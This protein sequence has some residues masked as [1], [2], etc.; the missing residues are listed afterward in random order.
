MKTKRTQLGRI[1]SRGAHD[2][3]SIYEAIDAG[4]LCHV[5][6]VDG[7]HPFVIPTA[8]GRQGDFLLLHGSVKSRLM[9][10]LAAGG[11]CCVTITHLDALVL[12]RSTFHHS[13]NYRSV[14]V[15]GKGELVA[16]EADKMEALKVITNNILPGRW[17]ETRLPNPG[18]MKATTVVR[19]PLKEASLKTRTGPPKDDQPDYELDIW[20]GL[21]PLQSGYLPPE[22]DPDLKDGVELPGSLGG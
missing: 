7:G 22:A 17:S 20:A 21:L 13:M 1:P 5:G 15:L 6:F 3:A 2:K 11:D 18:E 19:I 10:L 9:Q 8:Y 16:D 14:M 12:A 4:Y